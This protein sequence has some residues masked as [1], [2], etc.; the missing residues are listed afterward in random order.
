MAKDPKDHQLSIYTVRG[1][2][3]CL[4]RDS[5][6]SPFSPEIGGEGGRRPDEGVGLELI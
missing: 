6:T 5:F 1:Q 3:H 4:Q 2:E